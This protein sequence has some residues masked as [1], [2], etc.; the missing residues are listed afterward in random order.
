MQ[1]ENLN[2]SF[3]LLQVVPVILQ[4]CAATSIVAILALLFLRPLND[5]RRVSFKI[6]ADAGN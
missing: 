4:P 6:D 2:R 5:E 1:I 3:S